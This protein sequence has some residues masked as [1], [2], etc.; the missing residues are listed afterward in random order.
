MNK[1]TVNQIGNKDAPKNSGNQLIAVI[2][3][4]AVSEIRV[5]VCAYKGRRHMD[6]RI[7][8]DS[9]HGGER[10][11]TKQGISCH[12]DRAQELRAALKKVIDLMP[13]EPGPELGV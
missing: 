10:R 7:W 9:D 13:P 11:P 5:E 4:N 1:A 6:L 12:P 3:K 2:R 8:V